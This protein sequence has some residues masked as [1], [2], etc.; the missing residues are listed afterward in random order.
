MKKSNPLI[1]IDRN[2][3]EDKKYPMD[4]RVD[5]DPDNPP[6]DNK[7]D[8]FSECECKQVNKDE[9]IKEWK[10]YNGLQSKLVPTESS[11]L[12]KEDIK[13]TDTD[14]LSEDMNILDSEEFFNLIF[15]SEYPKMEDPDSLASIAGLPRSVSNFDSISSLDKMKERRDEVHDIFGIDNAPDEKSKNKE[16]VIGTSMKNKKPSFQTNHSLNVEEPFEEIINLDTDE[17]KQTMRHVTFAEPKE[18]ILKHSLNSHGADQGDCVVTLVSPK[19]SRLVNSETSTV[20]TNDTSSPGKL[21]IRRKRKKV[22]KNRDINT[23]VIKTLPLS[24]IQK[25]YLVTYGI[26]SNE[27]STNS[28]IKITKSLRKIIARKTLKIKANSKKKWSLPKPELKFQSEPYSSLYSRLSHF[29]T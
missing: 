27:C 21:S 12:S 18:Q 6:F 13:S 17:T 14:L 22:H 3:C 19:Y 29:E 25:K 1:N 23:D 2:I 15:V 9:H 16:N 10:K 4:V 20:E 8:I 5:I 26:I 28:D 11:C 24:Q 7:L